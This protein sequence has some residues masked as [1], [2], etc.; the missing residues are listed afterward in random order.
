M[1]K[2]S[3]NKMQIILTHSISNTSFHTGTYLNIINSIEYSQNND[4]KEQ[5]MYKQEI[6]LRESYFYACIYLCCFNNHQEKQEKKENFKDIFD[7]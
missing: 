3:G 6:K 1:G 2:K 7:Q 4:S 5:Q